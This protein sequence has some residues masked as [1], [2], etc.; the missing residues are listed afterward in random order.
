M[1]G[2]GL[3]TLSSYVN[4][5]MDAALGRLCVYVLDIA[6]KVRGMIILILLAKKPDSN[7]QIQE[8]KKAA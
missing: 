2:A 7:W 1:G 3:L 8:Q 4:T 5:S 6:D